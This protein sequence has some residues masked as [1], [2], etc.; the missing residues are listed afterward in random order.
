MSFPWRTTDRGHSDQLGVRGG[1][2]QLFGRAALHRNGRDGDESGDD[3]DR[4]TGAEPA[5]ARSAGTSRVAA[6]SACHHGYRVR[7]QCR[8]LVRG[9]CRAARRA[10]RGSRVRRGRDRRRQCGRRRTL[11]AP[12]AHAYLVHSP[13][14]TDR[15]TGGRTDRGIVRDRPGRAWCRA[16]DRWG[17][18]GSLFRRG[19]PGG[20]RGHAATPAHRG[21]YVDQHREQPRRRHRRGTS[22]TRTRPRRTVVGILGRRRPAARRRHAVLVRRGST[23]IGCRTGWGGGRAGSVRRRRGG[24]WWRRRGGRSGPGRR[25]VRRR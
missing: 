14:R 15:R 17:R 22:R 16:R 12:D 1:C 18:G 13:W 11:G 7:R 10:P 8:V 3:T 23:P 24:R 4:G 5:S 21:E 2:S 20:R 25:G 6:D 9:R 19:V